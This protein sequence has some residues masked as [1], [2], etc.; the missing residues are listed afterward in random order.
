MFNP[1]DCEVH[2]LNANPKRRWTAGLG[3]LAATRPDRGHQRSTLPESQ[4]ANASLGI[5]WLRYD[6]IFHDIPQDLQ[7]SYNI[8]R[9][10]VDD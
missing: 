10:S 4:D 5:P 2:R 1:V 7:K 9:E 6:K 3:P 8:F